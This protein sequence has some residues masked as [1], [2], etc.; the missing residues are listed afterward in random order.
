MWKSLGYI[1]ITGTPVPISA[2]TQKCHAIFFQQVRTNTGFILCGRS[3]LN[4]GTGTDLNAVLPIPT[5][6]SLPNA[7]VG[8]PDAMNAM[9]ASQYFVDGTVNGDKCLVSILIL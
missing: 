2:T 6:N 8:I 4:E 9:E 5:N 7:T 1:T 3:G